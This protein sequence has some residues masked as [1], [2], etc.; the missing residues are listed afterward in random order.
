MFLNLNNQNFEETIKKEKFVLVD[1]W[2]EWCS[3]CLILGPMLEKVAEGYQEK[4]VFAK[5]NLDENQIAS[6]KYNIDRI[7]S[8]IIFKNGNPISGFIGLRP[9][10]EIREW[11]EKSTKSETDQDEIEQAI[12]KYQE[13]AEKNG[14]KLNPN[15][16]I[17]ERL[18]KGLLENEKKYG[19]RYCPCRRILGKIEED[20]NKICPC[21]Q[22][23]EEIKKNGQCLCGLF[24]K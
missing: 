19:E 17:V 8:L 7:P 11:L 3:P 12:V 6:G 24:L 23:N 22:G 21:E 15:K 16:E 18:I 10:S 9:E 1:F 14:L 2:A 13:Y 4:I 5:A 20:K